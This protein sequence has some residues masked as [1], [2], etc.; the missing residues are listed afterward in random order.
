[1]SELTS[2][3]RVRMALRHEEP[4]KVPIDFGAMRSTGINAMAYNELKKYLNI[5]TPTKVYDIFQ[6]LAEPE[7]KILNILGADVVQLHRLRPSFGIDNLS[8]KEAKL[9]DGSEALVPSGL[10]PV[11][12]EHGDQDI[13]VDGNV[14]ARMPKD[15][16]Y[17][18]YMHRP[19]KDAKTMDDIDKVLIEEISDEEIE[20]L[21]VQAKKLYEETDRAILGNFGGSV[22]EQGQ[23][24]WGY[25]KYYLEMAL[26]PD[27]VRYYLD[28]KVD[29]YMRDLKKYLAAVGE[30]IDV[31]NF[32]DDLGTQE[33]SQISREMYK[34]IFKPYHAKMFQ[35]VRENY[36][37][38]K[39]FIHSCG[40]ILDM[41][42]ELID[43]GLEV[44]NPV[45]ISARNMDPAHLKK[46]FGKHLSF[47]GAGVSTQ[48]TL[49]FGTI[50]E[51]KQEVKDLTEIF[52]PGGGFVFSQIHNIQ[53]KVSPEKVMAVYDTINSIR[54][55]KK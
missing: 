22:F 6:Q 11:I 21:K 1:M 46:E 2:R 12:N 48:T 53:A 15:G 31:I 43:A 27:L 13:I 40:A 33:N 5:D 49:S 52:A 47:W 41:I 32:S 39:V 30:Y 50:E 19:Y 17:Y 24:E 16:F 10:N 29:A 42:P 9:Q 4:D 51:I 7:E 44:L 18:D 34:N 28:K 14:I 25:E 26:N 45:Q 38:V 35:Y 36:P 23:V 54:D 55:Y 8:W 3:E 20:Y 37:H